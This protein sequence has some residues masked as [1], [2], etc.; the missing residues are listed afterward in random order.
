[1]A[2][3]YPVGLDALEDWETETYRW[4]LLKD[5]IYSPTHNQ[6]SDVISVNGG[7]GSASVGYADQ[8][9][10]TPNKAV[11]TGEIDYQCSDPIWS[12]TAGETYVS[13][14]LY[15]FVTNDADSI[16]IL[17]TAFAAPILSE[18]FTTM[19]IEDGVVAILIES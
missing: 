6:V 5:D 12:L 16:P 4:A 9:V 2:S 15:K 3:F 17:M 19:F 18:N 8:D 14:L 13:A 7:R 10:D 1:M 11:F